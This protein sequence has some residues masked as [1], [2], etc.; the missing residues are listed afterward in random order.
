MINIW[1]K[2]INQTLLNILIDWLYTF[3][4]D[5]FFF[6]LIISWT[7]LTLYILCLYTFIYFNSERSLSILFFFFITLTSIHCISLSVHF[8]LLWFISVY[9]YPFS[10]LWSIQ[11]ILVT[12][13]RSIQF[14]YF[15]PFRSIRS[16]LVYLLKNGKKRHVWVE[17]WE[18][19]F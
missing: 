1:L 19:L 11:S 5:I 18:C 4:F 17:T 2:N 10:L 12:L 15:V 14:D 16:I 7:I 3:I 6:S 13:V 9:F 8:S